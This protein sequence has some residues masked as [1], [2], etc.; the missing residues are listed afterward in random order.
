MLLRCVD[1]FC[2]NDQH[3]ESMFLA[4]CLYVISCQQRFSNCCSRS[5]DLARWSARSADGATAASWLLLFKTLCTWLLQ[6]A[7]KIQLLLWCTH[8]HTHTHTHTIH[9][10]YYN[11]SWHLHFQNIS[12]CRTSSESWHFKVFFC[13]KVI[14]LQLSILL[15]WHCKQKPLTANSANS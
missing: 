9:I 12:V 11:S 3:F 7:S 14:Q 8:T 15:W 10:F 4:Q 13:I 5:T 6:F 1:W 2:I